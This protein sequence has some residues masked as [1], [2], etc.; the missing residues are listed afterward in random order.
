LRILYLA[1]I[2][3]PLERAN[4][5]QTI[6]TCHALACRGH[7]VTLLVRPDTASVARDPF[8]FYGL[9]PTPRLR[10]VRARVAGPA[11]V[12]RA[13]YLATGL[14]QALASERPDV[15]F[16]R[17]LGVAAAL[18]H[19]PRARRPPLVYESHGYAPVVSALLP[20]LIS[21]ASAPSSA[22]TRR[23]ER[24]EALV[25]RRAEG[26]VTITQ[27]LARE[28]ASRLG[29]RADV[30]V[31]A[32]GATVER[33]RTF[34]WEGPG[35]PGWVTYAGHLYPWKGVDVLIE[36]LGLLPDVRGRI[37]GG[38]AGERDLARLRGLAASHGVDG[39]IEFTGFVPPFEVRRWLAAADVLVLPNRATAISAAYTS[40][41]KLFE[42]LEAGRPI[43]ASKLPALAEVLRDE[44]NALLVEPD[45]PG[46]LAAAIARVSTD[47]ALAVR[48]ARRAFEDAAA[49]SWT[50]RAERLETTLTEAARAGKGGAR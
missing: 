32:D 26:Y 36:A 27:A 3:F 29:P 21:G 20:E 50:R 22:K 38:H 48:L 45:D 44:D 11:P 15:V 14:A 5:I 28:L 43:V 9:A 31:V 6:H 39:R 37:V 34:D 25:W 40:P 42:Y 1:D 24:R 49:F 30:A 19:V 35:R 46:A 23:L 18:L 13:L 41:L 7:D 4:G 16:T 2:R 8:E 10:I 17:D 33:E 12:R 47:R